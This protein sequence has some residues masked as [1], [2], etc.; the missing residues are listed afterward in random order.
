[1][2]TALVYS[3]FFGGAA[4]EI[5]GGIAVDSL[6]AV[7]VGGQTSST[8]LPVV[9]AYQ[10]TNGGALDAFTVKFDPNGALVAASYLG[11]SL[12]DFG[13]KLEIDGGG[14]V[15]LIGSTNSTDFP[16]AAALQGTRGGDYDA[17][18]TRIPESEFRPRNDDFSNATVI[19]GPSGS[20]TGGN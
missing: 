16:T 9:N 14:N 1:S 20:A 18:V 12:S 8:D 19:S 3:T 5:P 13:S 11:G 15:Y 7:I 10:T 4:G 2:G 6:G 17:F